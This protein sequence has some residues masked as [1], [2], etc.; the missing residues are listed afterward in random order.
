MERSLCGILESRYSVKCRE[1]F[2]WDIGEW[3]YCELK[4]EVCKGYWRVDIVSNVEK[5]L[6]GILESGYNVN[7]REEFVWDIGGWI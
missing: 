2:V 1:V 7:Y 5:S 4:R 3:I 6:R